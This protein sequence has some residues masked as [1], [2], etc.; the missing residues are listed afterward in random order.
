MLGCVDVDYRD[1]GAVAACVLFG[2]WT[3]AASTREVVVRIA[4]VEPYQ[5]GQF[6]KRELP[7]LLSV[8]EAVGEPL[9]VVVVDGYVWLADKTRPGLGAR[10]Y[11]ALDRRVP[12]IGVAKTRFAS[13]TLAVEVRR[14]DS[15]RP[16]Y[17]TAAGLE[18]DQAARYIASM[19]GEYRLP[20]L[21]KRVDQLCRSS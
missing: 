14:G 13:A 1:E 12:V 8:L 5:P 10:L 4:W 11:E 16:L 9:E 6:Y 17:V 18:P 3:D 19:H 2:A 21:L 20:A 7:C 15:Q